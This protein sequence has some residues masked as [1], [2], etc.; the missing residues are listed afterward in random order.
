MNVRVVVA[1]G[2]RL[3]R[4]ALAE[5]LTEREGLSVVAL[6]GDIEATV[7]QAQRTEADVVLVGAGLTGRREDL[8]MMCQ[9]LHVVAP[10]PRMLMLDG[11]GDDERLA[12]A[13]ESGFDGYVTG[14]VGLAGVTEAVKAIARGESVVPPAML[15]P[16]LKRLIERRRE[17]DQVADRLLALTPREREVLHLLIEGRDQSGVAAALFISPETARTHIQ[18]V[19]RKLGVHSRLEA[20]ALVG[21]AGLTDRL[22]RLIERNAS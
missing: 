11:Q 17:A 9:R 19:L 5:A 3:V 20:I 21:R 15:G 4:E 2:R 18:R 16:L 7:L 8:A 22:E 14:P 13:I 6:C 12:H 10:A 1:D